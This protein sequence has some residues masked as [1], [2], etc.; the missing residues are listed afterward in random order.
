M[1]LNLS[2]PPMEEKPAVHAETR[3]KLVQGLLAMLPADHPEIA[4]QSLQEPLSLLNRQSVRG[5]LRLKLLEIY[6]PALLEVCRKLA[7]KYCGQALPLPEASLK[8]ATMARSLLTEL[9]YGYKLAILDHMDRVFAIGGE[10]TLAFLSHRAIQA[11]DD[12]L[13]VSY[14]VY[15]VPPE[16][17]WSEIYRI[18]LHAAQHAV[19]DTIL[20]GNVSVNLA[21]K[22]AL[23]M[24]LA[25]PQRLVSADLVLVRDYLARFA[26]LSQLRPLGVPENPAGVFLVHLK[27]DN[28]PVPLAKHKGE[29]DMR[30][31]ILLITVE[32]VRQVSNDI[33]ELQ[34]ETSAG[35]AVLPKGVQAL[36]Y[37]DLLMHLLKYWALVPKR[38]FSRLTRNESINI[39]V[40]LKAIH[41]LLGG[42]AIPDENDATQE[43][44]A[45]VSLNFTDSPIDNQGGKKQGAA[46]WLVVNESAGGMAL[47]K[48]PDAAASLKVGELLGMRSDR[49]KG[50]GVGVVRWAN[51]GEGSNLDIGAQML[52]PSA[53]PVQVKTGAD[54]A[55]QSAL[56]LPE[57]AALAQPESL[58]TV[59][60]TY[61][62]GHVL[63][64][65]EDGGSTKV[66]ILATRLL[67]RTAS[68]ERFQFSH[69]E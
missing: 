6:R 38:A 46:R 45:A 54:S 29:A 37:L 67:E 58:L 64:F 25:N 21:F 41:H 7:Q 20:D 16:G 57:L 30:T 33:S 9:A 36:H 26:H 8:A 53:K 10:K 1:A 31:D 15:T 42:V 27:S 23:L 49:D 35:G 48:F 39:F 43:D 28:V 56:L 2:V 17:V 68:Y 3:P 18:Y 47:S 63:E 65:S 13:Q 51:A 12:L 66:R 14:Y 32:L 22:Q 60:G 44:D 34:N 59:S 40:G 50:W 4:A 24:S 69:V 52:A 5:D 55:Y 19:H 11:L 62:P 61:S